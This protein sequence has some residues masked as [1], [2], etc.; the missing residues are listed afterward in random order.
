MQRLL[1]LA[2]IGVLVIS[3]KKEPTSWDTSISSPILKSNLGISDLIADSLIE[4]GEDQTVAIRINENIFN[5]GIDSLIDIEP[6]TVTKI[7]SI[8]PLPEFTFNPGQTFY[9]SDE[10][11]EFE[12]IE[13]QL[14]E[15]ILKS[16]N[17]YLKAENTIGSELEFILKI[18]R[19]IKDGH[20]LT[21]TE[22]I[23]ASTSSGN[24]IL[25]MEIDMADYVLD[26]SG[27]DGN[28]YNILEVE[29]TLTN[30]IE[31]DPITVINTDFVNLF[32]S[33]S[34]LEVARA[35]G[36]FGSELLD[37]NEGSSFSVLEDYRESIVD[38]NSVEADLVFSNGFGVDIQASIYQLKAFN[39]YSESIVSLENTLIGST[40]N[41]SRATENGVTLI[42]YLK[43]YSLNSSNSN[44][45]E[46]IEIIPDSIKIL[47][48]ANL[49]PFGNISNYNDFLNAESSLRCDVEIK[50]PLQLS[51][52]N[53]I[54]SDTTTINWP[55][56]DNFEIS[57]GVLYLKAENSFPA[58]LTLQLTALDEDDNTLLDLNGYLS[59]PQ[60]TISASPDHL[61]IISLLKYTLDENAIEQME[62]AEKI[63]IRAGFETAAYPQEVNFYSGDSLRLLISTD[64]N[65]KISY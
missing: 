45:A 31:N 50:I 32:L 33:Y 65:S 27:T 48:N 16:G 55:D 63:A 4:I 58:E 41:L 61:P 51:L 25:E 19:A 29:F 47:A 60:S 26:L 13:A 12:G 46:F 56:D 57:S 38:L 20:S 30:P 53:L 44:I 6:D 23:P 35:I 54:L 39:N 3:C 15:A 11:F 62:K 9:N 43:T 24:G 28:S 37:L 14:S 42:P 40:I 1:F 5:F 36:Y 7:F 10:T 64:I 2:I 17:L 52:S 21:I 18:P 22:S 59:D 8:A 34:D 49:N